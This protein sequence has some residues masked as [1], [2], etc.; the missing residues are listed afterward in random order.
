[1]GSKQRRLQK[2]AALQNE[3]SRRCFVKKTGALILGLT[4]LGVGGW[5]GYKKLA[6]NPLKFLEI[7]KIVRNY[8]FSEVTSSYDRIGPATGIPDNTDALARI[9][10]ESREFVLESIAKLG[11]PAEKYKI[12]ALVENYGVPATTNISSGVLTYCKS[13]EKMLKEINGFNVPPVRWTIV[14]PGKSYEKDYNNRGFI[15]EG[16]FN[17]VRLNIKDSKGNIADSIG[18]TQYSN[19]GRSLGFTKTGERFFILGANKSAL[20]SSFSEII[21]WAINGQDKKYAEKYGWEES[22]AVAEALSEGIS[23]VLASKLLKRLGVQDPEKYPRE[24]YNEIIGKTR[25]KYSGAAILWAKQNGVQAT[26]D[27][28][29]NNPEDYRQ[30]LLTLGHVTRL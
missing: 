28:Y 27:A 12:E 15:A 8:S 6:D 18:S 30:K 17:V 4:T 3:E 20:V 22:T 21:P 13:A 23:Y 11:N 9:K 19:G 29:M 24:L 16:H 14:E 7:D 5:L 25:Y 10:E 1:M 26:F 2:Q